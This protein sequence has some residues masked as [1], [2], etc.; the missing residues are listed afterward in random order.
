MTTIV[1]LNVG[2]VKYITTKTT[3]E[4]VPDSFF[5]SLL[6]GKF[7]FTEIKGHI[8]IDRNG[9]IFE[10]I[11]SYL[12][13]INNWKPPRN[14]DL[15]EK[16]KVEAGFYLL[17]DLVK[18]CDETVTEIYRDTTF[19]I[20]VS[21]NGIIFDYLPADLDFQIKDKYGSN[22]YI[23]DKDKNLINIFHFCQCFGYS[24]YLTSKHSI[25][26]DNTI[27]FLRHV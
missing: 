13:N 10:H 11:L 24:V 2:G 25:D 6:S 15:A 3:L 7:S 16:I 26:D 22:K 20:N 8:F 12:R 27:Y 18:I 17:S 23:P 4:S 21:S 5:N 1:K 14:V 19:T 9:L